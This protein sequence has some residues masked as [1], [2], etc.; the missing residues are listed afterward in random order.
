MHVKPLSVDNILQRIE[1]VSF[2]TDKL[3]S[4]MSWMS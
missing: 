1:Y 3:G 4:I 2:D